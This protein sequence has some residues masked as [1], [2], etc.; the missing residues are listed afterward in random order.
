MM[1]AA[2]SSISSSLSLAQLLPR[3]IQGL[4]SLCFRDFH[5]PDGTLLG[6]EF[7]LF[8]ACK[9]VAMFC[10]ALAGCF[11]E[12]E[13]VDLE[14][15]L[16]SWSRFQ[17]IL[18]FFEMCFWYRFLVE[19]LVSRQSH[20]WLL[21]NLLRERRLYLEL[22]LWLIVNIQ[23]LSALTLIYSDFRNPSKSF[24]SYQVVRNLIGSQLSGL[25]GHRLFFHLGRWGFGLVVAQL[26]SFLPAISSPCWV[27]DVKPKSWEHPSSTATPTCLDHQLT[28]SSSFCLPST[29][30]WQLLTSVSYYKPTMASQAASI[31]LAQ[32]YNDGV[33]HW[34][35]CPWWNS[36]IVANPSSWAQTISSMEPTL[37]RFRYLSISSIPSHFLIW[38][39]L[40]TTLA[41]SS[42]QG[43]WRLLASIL[44]CQ[45]WPSPVFDL[46][47]AEAVLELVGTLPI[48]F[49]FGLW[50]SS[51]PGWMNWIQQVQTVGQ[52][53]VCFSCRPFL[54]SLWIGPWVF[55]RLFYTEFCVGY[56]I[57]RSI[58]QTSARFAVR[59]I[60]RRSHRHSTAMLGWLRSFA[61]RG[62]R[63]PAQSSADDHG[64][65]F[66]ADL[67][68]HLSRIASWCLNLLDFDGC[69]CGLSTSCSRYEPH[70][71]LI[72]AHLLC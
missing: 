34:T 20:S 38:C 37:L 16:C 63:Q 11:G 70:Q 23:L 3:R 36:L 68:P 49:G 32:G 25:S 58:S 43:H 60:G 52:L 72:S 65:W 40:K 19:Q 30:S 42:L 71:I 2:F 35:S 22:R 47:D 44:G 46:K 7:H 31:T 54:I 14:S 56:H 41:S 69:C 61:C 48:Y 10:E 15:C 39:S 29:Y 33:H 27:L 59:V 45:A 21:G 67:Q 57:T 18:C 12:Y 26:T 62:R 51:P 24:Y 4:I 53:I 28:T 8:E 66:W 17:M 64:W 5:P 50:V 1:F 55:E 13:E 6:F 9:L